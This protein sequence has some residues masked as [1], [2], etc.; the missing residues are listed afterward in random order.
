MRLN[1]QDERKFEKPNWPFKPTVG[2]LF[3]PDRFHQ[4]VRLHA[5]YRSFL[6]HCQIFEKQLNYF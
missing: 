4:P 1:E 5:R 3:D 2:G 6:I